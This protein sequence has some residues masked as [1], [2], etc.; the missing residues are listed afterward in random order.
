VT[1][2]ADILDASGVIRREWLGES[3]GAAVDAAIHEVIA[4]AK[5]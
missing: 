2:T 4:E 1:P 5:K 3:D